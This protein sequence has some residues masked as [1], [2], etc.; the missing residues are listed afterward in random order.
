MKRFFAAALA[1]CLLLTL[2]ACG[3]GPAGASGTPSP[4][5]PSGAASAMPESETP[6]A[7]ALSS[8]PPASQETPV[9]VAA[10]K[11]PTAMGMV[12]LMHDDGAAASPRYEFTIAASAD[13]LTPRLVQGDVDICALPANLA[14]VL[15]N[16]TEGQIQVLAVNTLGVLYLVESG[17]TIHTVE[18]LRGRTIY[19]SGKG[20]TPEYALRYM[21]EQNGIDPETDVAIEW[22]SEHAECVAALSAG[23]GGIA[24]LPQP[25]VTTAQ[26]KNEGIRVALD[27]TAEWEKLSSAESPATLITGVVVARKEFA[28]AHPDLVNGFL[29]DY[30]G[31]VGYVNSDTDGAAALVG[32]FDIVPE[33]VAKKALPQCN[34]TYIAGD[35]MREKLSGYLEALYGQNPQAVGG[36]LPQ[37]DFYYGC[38]LPG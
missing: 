23:E 26:M 10:L 22:K 35:E 16:N 34:I 20:S 3:D 18:D 13:E 2:A 12:K 1:L 6:S 24:M 33:A 36:A 30:H 15:Y 7:S 14:S 5:T 4:E 25:F 17:D 9:R 31:S 28:E 11:G 19:S 38:T 27:L 29:S 8:Q 32:E 21:L 37:G